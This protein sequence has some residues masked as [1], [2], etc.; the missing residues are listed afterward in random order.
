MGTLQ[1]FTTSCMILWS[2]AIVASL[3]YTYGPIRKRVGLRRC[4][5]FVLNGLVLFTPFLVLTWVG[6]NGHGQVPARS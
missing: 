3:I 1:Y 6:R 4:H 2:A 5:A